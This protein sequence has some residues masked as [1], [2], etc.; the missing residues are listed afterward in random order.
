MSESI[1][2][3]FVTK[4]SVYFSD[5]TK[6]L[7]IFIQVYLTNISLIIFRQFVAVMAYTVV[8]MDIHVMFLR[9]NVT[10]VNYRQNGLSKLQQT[11]LT[12]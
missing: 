9:A 12:K 5:M 10:R 6:V 8:L 4:F 11:K 2:F 3:L 1:N 7:S